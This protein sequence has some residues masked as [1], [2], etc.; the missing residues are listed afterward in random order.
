MN[1]KSRFITELKKLTTQFLREHQVKDASYLDEFGKQYWL[2]E[3]LEEI[4]YTIKDQENLNEISK[5]KATEI[6]FAQKTALLYVFSDLTPVRDYYFVSS[7]L[8]EDSL[9]IKIKIEKGRFGYADSSTP[10]QRVV[11]IVFDKLDGANNFIVKKF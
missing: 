7:N 5:V 4:T 3:G 6:D 1:T 8:K 11:L 9:T 10:Y 2:R